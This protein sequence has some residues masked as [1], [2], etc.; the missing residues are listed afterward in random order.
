MTNSRYADRDRNNRQSEHMHK[1]CISW[2]RVSTSSGWQ[3][4]KAEG[5]AAN[6]RGA[7]SKWKSRHLK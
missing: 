2:Q 7:G 4:R 5:L 3:K 6:K 1:H